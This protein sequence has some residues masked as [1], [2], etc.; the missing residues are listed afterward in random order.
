MPSILLI[1]PSTAHVECLSRGASVF[2]ANFQNIGESL[3][4]HCLFICELNKFWRADVGERESRRWD[5][6]GEL[7][8]GN[9]EGRSL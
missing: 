9:A 6:F 7:I 3:T 8:A 1:S 2:A 5:W 4:L